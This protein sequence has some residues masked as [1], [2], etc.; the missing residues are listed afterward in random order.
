MADTTSDKR[1]HT[2]PLTLNG[3]LTV[4]GNI[5]GNTKVLTGNL[6]IV[7]NTVS[8]VNT[9]GNLLLS[10]MGTGAV[11]LVSGDSSS[12]VPLKWFNSAGTFSVG[13]KAPTLAASTTWTLPAADAVSTGIPIS[14][15]AS[16]ILSFNTTLAN[17]VSV[18]STT[19]VATTGNITTV[20]S[21]TGN[22]TTV[23]ATTG[24]ITTV[25]STTVNSTNVM[26]GANAVAGTIT[27]YPT[28]TAKGTLTLTTS[29][30]SG[31]TVTNIN[32]AAQAAARTLTVPD[33]GASTAN[34][35][36]D[37]GTTTFA[38]GSQIITDKGTATGNSVTI[39]AM[40]GTV[41]TGDLTS[42]G[43]GAVA[44]IVLNN[45]HIL[46]SSVVLGQLAGGGTNVMYGI[47]LF[48]SVSSGSAT[49]SIVNI[50]GSAS[51]NGN[52]VFNFL[53]V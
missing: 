31:N 25:N 12:A 26:A 39:N 41:T 52:V 4:T 32:V 35:V 22:I 13:F 42:L 40:S 14:S 27:V 53:V 10:P 7:G 38:S 20:N 37:A 34:F 49:F 29:S 1:V 19:V 3:S 45:S 15:N 44:N 18:T 8:V 24:N 16:G 51:L 21:T 33:R 28:T 5:L 36:L 46:T 48:V 23:A 9:D 43:P 30:N 2:G 6:S 11:E 47:Q 17:L 50:H